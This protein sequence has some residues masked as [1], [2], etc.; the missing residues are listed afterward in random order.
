MF[1]VKWLQF[2]LLSILLLAIEYFWPLEKRKKLIGRAQIQDIF[3]WIIL[4]DV[5]FYNLIDSL[6]EDKFHSSYMQIF[7]FGESFGFANTFSIHKLHIVWQFLVV[8]LVME[9]INYASHRFFNHSKFLWD[10][11]KVHH[12]AKELNQFSDARHHPVSILFESYL[13]IIPT[14]ILLNPKMEALGAY[15]AIGLLWGPLIHLNVGWK[16]PFPFS[17]ILSSP[18]THRWHHARKKGVYCNYAGIFIFYDVLFGTFYSPEESCKEI[19]F[20]GDE[21]YIKTPLPMLVYPFQKIYFRVM[22][23]ELKKGIK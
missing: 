15:G 13:L 3:F 2:L 21:T 17:H 22:K 4:M 5:F 7:S 1:D 9:F 8:F 12:S 14:L 18:H 23:G 19:G 10:F 6:L 16:W 20:E 11:H